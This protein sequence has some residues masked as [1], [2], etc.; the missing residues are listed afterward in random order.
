MSRL[1][2]LSAVLCLA[3]AVGCEQAPRSE[4]R[5]GLASAALTLDPRLAS[6]AA[7]TRINRLLYR[8]LTDF[9][10]NSRPIP[11]L[12][13]WQ[14]L[15]PDHYR[16]RLLVPRATFHDGHTL[17]AQD[18]RATYESLLRPEL[19][20]PHRSALAHIAR[21]EVVD[22]DTLDFHLTRPDSLFPGFLGIGILPTERIAAGH[23]FSHEPIGSGAFRFV[24][25]PSADRLRVERRSDGQRFE[26]S[27]I[28][29]PTVRVLKLRRGEIDLLQNDLP[30]EMIR[31]LEDS[32]DIQVQRGPGITFAYLGFNLDDSLTGRVELR[33][34]IAH[35]IDRRAIVRYLFQDNARPGESILPA[36]HWAGAPGLKPYRHDPELARAPVEQL[37]AETGQPVRLVYKTSADPFR[38]RLATVLQAQLA[39]AGIEVEIKSL[40]WGTF[41]GDVKAGRFQ[42]Y[43]LAWVGVQ[44]PDIFRY[45][46]HSDSL[47]P[48]G[49]NRGRYRSARADAL[50]EA[51]EAAEEEVEQSRLLRELQTHLHRALVYVPLWHEGN[52]LARRRAIAGYTL[53]PAGHYDGLVKTYWDRGRGAH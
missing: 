26:F 24:D 13:D 50:I 1:R 22:A 53:H 27:R 21:I 47:P 31:H 33:R 17:T 51:F 11:E 45:A 2:F 25:R 30:P 10:T 12:A 8:S 48:K 18:V 3:T 29:D 38:L 43:S 37:R 34:A 28:P 20:S 52:V 42:L 7:S 5:M 35:A 49:A 14:R 46:F 4:I 23:D 44:S 39:A 15:A 36:S 9:D 16:F 32:A 40:D 6:D 41:F 19:G